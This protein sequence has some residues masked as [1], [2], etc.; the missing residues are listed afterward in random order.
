[1]IMHAVVL[2]V[3]RLLRPASQEYWSCSSNVLPLYLY[4]CFI[5]AQL[6]ALVNKKRNILYD[7]FFVTFFFAKCRVVA[8]LCAQSGTSRISIR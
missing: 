8:V 6:I 3:C 1:M 7:I 4:F 2:R 5:V